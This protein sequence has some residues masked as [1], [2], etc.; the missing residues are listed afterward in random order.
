MS[1]KIADRRT[2]KTKKAIRD[3]LA[4]LL[5][6]KD[7]TKVTVKD[8][9][10]IADINRVT[11]YKHYL[12]VYDLYDKTE[13]DILV[14][15]GEL[16]LQLEELPVD[17]VFSGLIDFIDENRTVFK[18]I[19][20]PNSKAT[21]FA[22][23]SKCIDGLLRQVESEKLGISLDDTRL[24]YLTRYRSQGVIAVIMQWVSEDFTEPKDFIVKTISELDTNTRELYKSVPKNS[25]RSSK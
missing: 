20:S 15:I 10:D 21:L 3:A 24:R 7:L 6:D 16:V 18:M 12:D 1:E 5:K 23:F 8:I 13:Q 25:T 17:K 4:I 2:L 11:F 9:T 19:F 22:K 14:E